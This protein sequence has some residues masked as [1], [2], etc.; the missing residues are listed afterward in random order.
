L[1]SKR[2]LK[3]PWAMEEENKNALLGCVWVHPKTA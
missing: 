3:K 2:R 1:G